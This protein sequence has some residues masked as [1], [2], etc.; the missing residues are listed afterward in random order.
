[1][2]GRIAFPDVLLIIQKDGTLIT[3]WFQKEIWSGRYLNFHS[4]VPWVNKRNSVSILAEQVFRLS[5]NSLQEKNISLLVDTL[6]RD[7]NL[8]HSTIGIK[9]K[10]RP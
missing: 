6:A 4:C 10:F 8:E 2:E 9:R 7:T 5:D 1:M 3:D